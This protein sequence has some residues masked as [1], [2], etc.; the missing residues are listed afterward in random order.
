MENNPALAVLVPL[1]IIGTF[2]AGIHAMI[3]HDNGR[4]TG[5][6][7]AAFVLTWPFFVIRAILR[8][9]VSLVRKT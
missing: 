9:F 8:G 7:V 1:A 5:A 4:M 6:E 2:I 3:S